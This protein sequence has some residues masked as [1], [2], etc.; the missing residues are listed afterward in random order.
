MIFSRAIAYAGLTVLFW[1]FAFTAV[2]FALLT[3]VQFWR[4]DADAVP[5]TTISGSLVFLGMAGLAR[6]G[7]AR[8][9]IAK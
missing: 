4:G 9:M 7:A 6:W 5:L 3:L 2:L 8:F 1:L